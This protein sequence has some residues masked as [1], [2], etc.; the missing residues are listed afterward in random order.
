LAKVS[1]RSWTSALVKVLPPIGMLRCQIFRPLVTTRSVESTPE[2]T[3]TIDGGGLSG[4]IVAG[5]GS[6]SNITMFARA[7]GESWSTSTAMPASRSG[8]SVL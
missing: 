5:S 1:L 4:S 6:W 3:S 2:E 8:E 7:I